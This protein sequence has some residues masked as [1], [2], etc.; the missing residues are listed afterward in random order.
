[1]YIYIYINR[2]PHLIPGPDLIPGTNPESEAS[3]YSLAQPYSW[4]SPHL[5]HCY[6]CL[7]CWA[8]AEYALV[9]ACV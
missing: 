3:P 9:A 2:Q 1:M 4:A 5:L 8:F 7:V 6:F